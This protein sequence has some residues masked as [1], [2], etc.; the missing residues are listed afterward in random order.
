MRQTMDDDKKRSFVIRLRSSVIVTVLAA[1]ALWCGELVLFLAVAAVS[2]IGLFEMLQALGLRKTGLEIA[3]FMSA[4]LYLEA[5]WLNW[6]KWL[7]FAIFLGFM[8]IMGTYVFTWPKYT[9]EQAAQ[10]VFAVL[11]IP[12]MLSFIYRTEVLTE[13]NIAC[14][15]LTLLA[16]WCSDV[17][18]YCMGM[19][20]GK[21]K[22]TPLLSPKKTVEGAVGAVVFAAGVGALY[23]LIFAN[24]LSLFEKPWLSV[25]I[26][27]ACGSILA[28]IG[29]LIASAIKRNR[30]IKDY[31][32]L[33]P[34]HGGIM[35]RFDSVIVTAPTIYYLI[36]LLM[37]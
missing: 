23:G 18:A 29:D 5:V 33:I 14:T 8:L 10:T 26:L 17:G 25:M 35:D 7:F 9:A 2:L 3:A 32:T 4:V 1:A 27:F 19:L 34:G 12:V 37:K 21:T 28:Q 6:D 22:L 15:A 24:A 13:G 20:F 31:G 30:G 11:Y 36:L 16:A